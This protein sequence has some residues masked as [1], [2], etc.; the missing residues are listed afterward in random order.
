MKKYQKDEKN[1]GLNINYIYE[2][3]KLMVVTKKDIR[4]YDM[5][6]GAI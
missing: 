5:Q 4:L 1:V 6:T 3:N 2:E